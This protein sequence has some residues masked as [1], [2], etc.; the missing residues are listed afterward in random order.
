MILGVVVPGLGI[1]V[2][3]VLARYDAGAVVIRPDKDSLWV[4]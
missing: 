1:G 2:V 4:S 3:V